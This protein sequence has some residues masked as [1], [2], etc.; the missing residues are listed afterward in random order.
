MSEVFIDD[1]SLNDIANAL[2]QK[3][4]LI[5][6]Y[7]PREM[8]PAIRALREFVPSTHGH[9]IRIIQSD[10]QT[11]TVRVFQDNNTQVYDR[12]FTVSEPLWKFEA[13]IT[14][15]AGWVAGTLNY[16]G[17]FS[18]DRDYVIQA[19]PATPIPPENVTHLYMNGNRDSFVGNN[20]WYVFYSDYECTQ[21]VNKNNI[22]GIIDVTD[23]QN[24]GM[25]YNGTNIFGKPENTTSIIQGF[26]LVREI[27]QSIDVS[28]KDTLQTCF[29]AC[30][31]LR[32][33]DISNWNTINCQNFISMFDGCDKLKNTGDI[34]YWNTSNLLYCN[35][36]FNG[37][38]QIESIDLS[39]WDT[40]KLRNCNSMFRSCGFL[41]AVDISDW[42]TTM[43]SDSGDMFRDDPDLRYIIMDSQQ[44][45]F[46]GSTAQNQDGGVIFPNPNTHVKYLVPDNLVESYKVHPNWVSRAFQIESINNYTI[47]RY[48]GHVYVTPNI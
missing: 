12:S 8:P 31:E 24:N 25:P 37:C 16:N 22:Y 32:M 36:M 13:T 11:I 30:A 42:D 1:S 6:T 21:S 46:T 15:D 19:Q 40:R 9:A 17:V 7:K 38:S 34:S 2:R 18:I 39:H 48:G 10:N 20:P 14:P 43:I 29:S 35:S 47:D 41:I 3:N 4:G 26:G 5:R 23:K 44:M 33:V 28:Q 27:R 45:K